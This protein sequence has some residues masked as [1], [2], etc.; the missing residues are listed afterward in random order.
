MSEPTDIDAR[1]QRFTA[2]VQA[3]TPPPLKRHA[4]L[5]PFKDG[6]IELRQKGASLLLIRELLVTVNVS[7]SSD[8]IARFLADLNGEPTVRQTS[9]RTQR[10]RLA[11]PP[12][13]QTQPPDKAATTAALPLSPP[14]PET[15][16]APPVEPPPSTPSAA[17]PTPKP[18][19]RPRFRGPRIADP[20]N[21]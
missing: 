20:K 13:K 3:F 5:M 14:V 6:I 1:T 4:K 21:L 17:P 2:A 12:A 7:V 15:P 11:N 18:T 9:K 8:T 16:P 10:K 19:E